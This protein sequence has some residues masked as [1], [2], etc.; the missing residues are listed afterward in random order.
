MN[1]MEKTVYDLIVPLVD[2]VA[3]LSVKTMETLN[4]D[5]I[6]I[7]VYANSNDTARLIGRKGS[8]AS[9]LR[10]TM[11]IAS[12]LQDKKISIKFESY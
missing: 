3:S 10:Q 12:R 1:A 11:M 2:D 5:E 6:L 8:M 7:Y 4:T 9:A